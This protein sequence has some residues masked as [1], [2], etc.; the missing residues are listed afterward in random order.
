MGPSGSGK[1]TILKLLLREVLPTSGEVIFDGQASSQLKKKEIALLRQKIGIVFQ[2]FRLLPERTVRE[3]IQV[4]LAVKGIK[5]EEW[6]E[7][8]DD[9]LKLV[10]LFDKGDLFP[11]QLSGGEIQRTCLARALV[12]NPQVIFADE[13]TGNLDWETAE[14]IVNLLLK[15]NKKGKTIIVASHHKVII[16]KLKK[17]VIEL[18][19]GRIIK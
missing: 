4:A 17:R 13:P 7:R 16:S 12:V 5:K 6:E 9:V 3:N 8:V 18:K 11:S 14:S 1:T 10:G 2:D 15:A 19:E